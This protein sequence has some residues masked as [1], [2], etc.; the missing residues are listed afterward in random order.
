VTTSSVKSFHFDIDP[1]RKDCLLKGLDEID[2]TLEHEADIATY[3]QRRKHEAPW[4]F[5]EL[6]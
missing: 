2:L 6:A 5:A 3:E 1:F 4:M